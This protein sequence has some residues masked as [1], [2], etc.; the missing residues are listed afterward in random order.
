M[1]L[2]KIRGQTL[3]ICFTI[4]LHIRAVYKNLARKDVFFLQSLVFSVR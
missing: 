2:S 3:I 4:Y 1:E